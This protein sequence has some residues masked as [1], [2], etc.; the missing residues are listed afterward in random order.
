MKTP[1]GSTSIRIKTKHDTGEHILSRVSYSAFP[2]EQSLGTKLILPKTD[3]SKYQPHCYFTAFDQSQINR[4]LDALRAF[5]FTNYM[6][7][8]SYNNI[9]RNRLIKNYISILRLKNTRALVNKLH[10]NDYRWRKKVKETFLSSMQSY[11][12]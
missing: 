4:Y 1:K 8:G 6:V 5:H 11:D 10:K 12:N 3:S 9:P 2:I 7:N